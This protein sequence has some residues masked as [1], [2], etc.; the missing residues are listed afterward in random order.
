[1]TSRTLDEAFECVVANSPALARVVADP[2]PFGSILRD[3]ATESVAAFSNLGQDAMLIAPSVTADDAACAQL[4]AFVRR[5]PAFQQ[6]ALWKS[7]GREAVA[8]VGDAPLW[9]STS[10]LGVHWVHVRLDSIP[11]YYTY[12][13]YLSA[14]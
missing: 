9:I 1:M 11:K 12:L 7:V 14:E 5:A 8:L 13:P 4:A 6:Q 10:G 3:G 2:R